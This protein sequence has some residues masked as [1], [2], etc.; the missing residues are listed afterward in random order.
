VLTPVLNYAVIGTVLAVLGGNGS[1]S[2]IAYYLSGALIFSLFSSVVGGSPRIMVAN[3]GFIKKVA[4]PKVIYVIN[5]A[6]LEL[7]IFFIASTVFFALALSFGLVSL[8]PTQLLCPVVAF[9]LLVFAI[10]AASVIS[11]ISVYFRD[12][13]HMVPVAL[14]AAFFLTPAVY[15]EDNLP[16]TFQAV[17]RANP[18]YPFLKVFRDPLLTGVAPPLEYFGLAALYATVSFVA[19]IVVLQRFD[20]RIVFRL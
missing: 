15:Q 9:M 8:A 7:V 12:M 6:G 17:V 5:V 16:P 19:G 11:V 13:S 20:N 3:E 2:F 1:R 14:Q 4:L 10:G 18:L